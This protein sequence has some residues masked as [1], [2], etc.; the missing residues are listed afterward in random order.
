[1][2]SNIEFLEHEHEQYEKSKYCSAVEAQ[3]NDKVSPY[4]KSGMKFLFSGK[5]SG[6]VILLSQIIPRLLFYP[7]SS[8]S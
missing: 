5:G 3:N 1:M 7:T 6:T 2:P 4:E 8:A